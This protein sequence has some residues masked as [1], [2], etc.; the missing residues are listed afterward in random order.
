MLAWVLATSLCLSVTSRSY[1]ET[2]ER[3][4]LGVGTGASL[5]PTYTVLTGNSGISKNKGTS[6]L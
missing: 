6:V 5:H 3:I 1:I 2:A 4:E